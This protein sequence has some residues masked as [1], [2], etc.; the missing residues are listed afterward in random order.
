MD[1]QD[2]TGGTVRS[3]EELLQHVRDGGPALVAL[4]GGVDSA[5]VAAVAH[6]ALGDAALAATVLSSAISSSE[7][8]TARAAALAAGI[9]HRWV[10][11]EPLEEPRY[12]ENGA[13]RCYHCRRVE[14][15]AL[16]QLASAEGLRQLVDGIHVDDLSDERPGLRA[17]EEA[18][19]THPLLWAG[20]GKTRVRAFAR[21]IGLPNAD[22]PSNACL[23]SRVARGQSIS[24]ELLGRIDL[25]EQFLNDRG[26]RRVRVRVHGTAARIEVDR[27][28]VVLLDEPSVFQEVSAR[29]RSLGFSSVV[30][31]P[32]GYLSREL[33]PTVR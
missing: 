32:R 10:R 24:A 15:G 14:T 2:R 26:F 20:W 22:R 30:V 8:D 7:V 29:L 9:R 31:D 11:A 1:A 27:S 16:R 28:E 25:A 4:S 6:A 33:L 17:M 3:A 21:S 18:G 23:A 13:D 19:F 5:V 12:R